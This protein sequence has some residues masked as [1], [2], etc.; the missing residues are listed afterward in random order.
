M[1]LTHSLSNS[2]AAP[3]ST[4]TTKVTVPKADTSTFGSGALPVSQSVSTRS[5]APVAGGSAVG[6]GVNTGL[7]TASTSNT[8]VH[9]LTATFTNAHYTSTKT[10]TTTVASATATLAA[11]TWTDWKKYKA[12]GVNLGGWLELE[13]V[14]DQYWWNQYA[15]NATDEWTFC[16][17]LGSRCGPILEQHYATYITTDDIDKVA[18]VGKSIH[19]EVIL[20]QFLTLYDLRCQHSPHSHYLCCMDQGPRLCFVPR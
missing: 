20:N 19:V 13:E 4:I 3:T 14:F 6:S 15:P 5:L 12:N 17:T 18:A 8:A 16:E 10:Y 11:G 7:Y 1:L 2:Q 9:T